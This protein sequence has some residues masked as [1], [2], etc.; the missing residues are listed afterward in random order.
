[1]DLSKQLFTEKF[2]KDTVD[3]FRKMVGIKF[4]K[5]DRETELIEQ[6]VFEKRSGLIPLDAFEEG[7]FKVSCIDLPAQDATLD[8]RKWFSDLMR[9]HDFEVAIDKITEVYKSNA[10]KEHLSHADIRNIASHIEMEILK[11][12]DYITKTEYN[13][14][15]GI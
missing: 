1:M 8:G 12:E 11:K 14:Y 5:R 7:Y 6:P 13:S 2:C 10:Q 9:K 15:M 4:E 3:K